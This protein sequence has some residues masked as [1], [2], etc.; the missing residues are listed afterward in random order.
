MEEGS[1]V[2]VGPLSPTKRNKRGQLVHKRERLLIVNLYKDLK[3]ESPNI[4]KKEAYG[5]LSK[6]TGFGIF[7][8]KKTLLEYE[9]TGNVTSP[10]KKKHRITS[11]QR[12]DECDRNAIRRKVHQFYFNKELPTLAKVLQTVNNDEDL[13]NFKRTNFWKLLKELNFTFV[14]RRRNSVLTERDD[15]I[16]WW[17]NYLKAVRKFRED[18][19]PIYYLDETWVNAGDVSAKV[20][21]DTTIKSKRDAFL[22]GLST[23]PSNPTGKGKRLIVLHIGS[24]AGFVPDGLLCFESKKNTA[25]YHDEM[26]G[27]TFLEWFENILP[28]LEDNAVIVMDNAPYH[29]VKLEKV[30][31]ASWKKSGNNRMVGEQRQGR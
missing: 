14:G 19:R 28:S 30:P 6:R 9:R 2:E 7:S 20:W 22:R 3:E 12:V 18:G 26:N 24:T 16:L 1:D 23:G 15:L 11:N 5:I 10:N 8:I 25:D 27:D 17:R 31:N 21:I 13:P 29:S 4:S